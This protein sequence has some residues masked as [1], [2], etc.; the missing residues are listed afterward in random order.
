M[1]HP[2]LKLG[3]K[4]SLKLKVHAVIGGRGGRG[5]GAVAFLWSLSNL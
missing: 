1:S 2:A 5:E 4:V 3:L